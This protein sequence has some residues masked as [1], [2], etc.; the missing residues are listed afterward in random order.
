M[1]QQVGHIKTAKAT[2][3]LETFVAL[4][5]KVSEGMDIISYD[6]KDEPIHWS[7]EE[8]KDYALEMLS[9][10]SKHNVLV[11]ICLF[12]SVSYLLNDLECSMREWN[13]HIPKQ[14]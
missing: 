7:I 8:K 9:K 1:E 11:N 4:G 10:Y 3:P 5:G 6:H 12:D 14:D 2:I 13:I